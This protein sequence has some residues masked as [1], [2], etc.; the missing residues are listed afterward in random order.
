MSKDLNNAVPKSFGKRWGEWVIKNRWLALIGSI[1]IFLSAA[2]GGVMKFDSDYHVFFSEDNPQLLA[3]DALQNTYTKDDNVFIVIERKDGEDLFDRETLTAL[4]ELTQ[5]SW[6]VPYSSR[7]DGITNFQYTRAVEDDLYVDDLISNA[8]GKTDSQLAE[9]KE[10]TTTDSRIVHRL[11]NEEGTATAVNVTVR[12]PDV[13]GG[14][15]AEIT[16][17]AR[18]MVKEFE[19]KYPHLETHMSGFVLLNSAF[20]EAANGDAQTLTPL[21][22]LIVIIT[23]LIT[24]RTIT[25]TISSLMVIIF[26][27]ASA[28][29]I[30]AYMGIGL[31]PPSA[32]FINIVLTLAVA[33][34]IHILITFIQGMR[35][36]MAKNDAIIESLRVNYMPVFITSLTTVVGFLSMNF[37]DSPPFRDLG[38]LTAVGMTGAF[39]FSV[40][41]LPSLLSILPVKLK[42]RESQDGTAKFLDRLAD[43]VI[44]QK[45]PV[46]LASTA[47]IIVSSILVTMNELNDE[48]IKYFSTDI[49]FRTDTDHISENLTGIYTMEFSLNAGEEGGINNPEYLKKVK[50]FELWLYTNPEVVH[51]N[52]F[53]DVMRH[54]NK[55]MHGDNKEYFRVPDEREQAAQ[56]LFLYELSLPFGLDLNNQV[57]VDKSETRVIVTMKNIPTKQMLKLSE[58][59]TKWLEENAP[60]HMQTEAVSSTMM[61]AHLSER[62]I[63]SM[64]SGTIVAILLI[65]FI[66][67]IAIRSLK[68]GL[69][70]LIPNITP[71][72]AGLGLWG[73]FY[74]YINTG[75]SIVFGMTLGIIVD[76][77]VHFLS[78]YLRARREHGMSAEDAVRY[79]FSTVGKALVVTSFVLVAGFAVIAQSNFGLNSDMAKITVL[80]ISLAL[81][82]DF[83][84]LPALLIY[85]RSRREQDEKVESKK[86]VAEVETA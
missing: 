68:F 76:D 58:A 13:D 48:F 1:A 20:F 82:L 37:S 63:I 38:N 19:E 86:L 42:V 83:F 67:G 43:F 12:L 61:F 21:M 16:A 39:F 30:G 14:E 22:F 5:Q 34:S 56:F 3:Y 47:F 31:T 8:Q 72:I 46:L 25:G 79:A 57:N 49:K 41:L 29:G 4:E 60:E 81:I 54:V 33:D 70:S 17:Y 74:G 52:A 75:I 77:T 35:K 9:L 78:K 24:T 15:N 69:I 27:I 26:S 28:M 23:I 7:V 44:L 55:S 50:E 85:L 18:N 65:S 64:I 53:T 36:G 11:M 80:I 51:V 10:I 32:S 66:L 71:V 2:S 6:Q 45:R 59:S 40:T 84:M 62:Q 73:L